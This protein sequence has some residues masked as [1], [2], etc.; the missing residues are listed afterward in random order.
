VEQMTMMKEPNFLK[1]IGFGMMAGAAVGAAMAPRKKF[2]LKK[3]AGKAIKT[4]G[5]V[6]EEISDDMGF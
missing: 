1:G 3:A 2:P 5:H 4:V 6:M